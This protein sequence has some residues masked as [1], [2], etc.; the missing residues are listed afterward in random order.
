MTTGREMRVSDR[1]RQTAADRLKGA[2]EE[3]RLDFH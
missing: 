2:L 3:G 1:E